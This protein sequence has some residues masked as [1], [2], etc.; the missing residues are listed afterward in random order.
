M[1][2]FISKLVERMDKNRMKEIKVD[3]KIEKILDPSGLGILY[4]VED[5]ESFKNYE[6]IKLILKEMKE[7]KN[8]YVW[9]LS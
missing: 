6:V 9:I 4:S 2:Y 5:L 8:K 3:K 7:C 1:Y